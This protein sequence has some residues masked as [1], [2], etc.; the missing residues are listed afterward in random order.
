MA[1]PVYHL[2]IG[3]YYVNA[4]SLARLA[5]G[6]LAIYYYSVFGRR[7]DASFYQHKTRQMTFVFFAIEAAA[8]LLI[9][10]IGTSP[11][12]FLLREIGQFGVVFTIFSVSG[13]MIVEAAYFPAAFAL[14]LLLLSQG[15]VRVAGL[16]V[17]MSSLVSMA[18]VLLAVRNYGIYNAIWKPGRTEVRTRA[19]FMLSLLASYAFQFVGTILDKDLGVVVDISETIAIALGLFAVREA[20]KT[21]KVL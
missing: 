8:D 16:D 12:L 5:L 3:G 14:P 20:A 11:S 15:I 9:G 18:L 1:H 2:F 10:A 7:L 6:L 17:D 4:L 21:E 13:K 19:L